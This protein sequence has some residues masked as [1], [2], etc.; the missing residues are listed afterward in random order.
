MTW[1]RV[2]KLWFVRSHSCLKDTILHL[3]PQQFGDLLLSIISLVLFGVVDTRKP[4]CTFRSH[5]T[6][7]SIAVFVPQEDPAAPP[8]LGIKE[9]TTL[10]TFPEYLAIHTRKHAGRNR[11]ESRPYG[12]KG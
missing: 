5:H 12:E 2:E 1:G 11:F 8:S 4:I 3:L 10:N 6:I 7:A 9:N